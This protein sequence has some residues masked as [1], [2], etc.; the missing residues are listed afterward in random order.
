MD[1]TNWNLGTVQRL[2]RQEERDLIERMRKGDETARERL[3]TCNLPLCL[4]I[5]KRYHYP[6]MDVQDL[7]QYGVIGLMRAIQDFDPDRCKLSTYAYAWIRQS[8]QHAIEKFGPIVRSSRKDMRNGGRR[9]SLCPV[10]LSDWQIDIIEDDSERPADFDRPRLD[11]LMEQSGLDER[12][13]GIM[14][15]L[16]TG[17]TLRQVGVEFG[18]SFERVRQIRLAACRQIQRKCCAKLT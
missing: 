4:S 2:S 15:L 3:I 16:A 11:D 8:I 12:T 5:A 13:T 6:T 18:I 17:M 7:A 14:R 9:I 1:A 10:S